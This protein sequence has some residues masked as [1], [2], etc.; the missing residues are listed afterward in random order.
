MGEKSSFKV[1]RKTHEKLPKF[2]FKI[3]KLELEQKNNSWK[4]QILGI[5]SLTKRCSSRT[6]IENSP[7]ML[8]GPENGENVQI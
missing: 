5:K 2:D 8:Q 6:L 7:K 4:L 3:K 1:S